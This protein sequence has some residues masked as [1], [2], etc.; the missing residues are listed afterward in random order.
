MYREDVKT[1]IKVFAENALGHV[2][3]KIAACCGKDSDVNSHDFM[4]AD[5]LESLFLKE[6]QQFDLN[7]QTDVADFV[8]KRVPPLANSKRPL[9]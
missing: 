9:R 2:F 5:S 8:R 7:R 1:I 3:L 6:T 4:S